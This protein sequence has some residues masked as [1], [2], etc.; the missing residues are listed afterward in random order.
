MPRNV[1]D[2]IPSH[3][4]SIRDVP[5]PEE[6]RTRGR[7]ATDRHPEE[8][9]IPIH[10][11]VESEE[12]HTHHYADAHH[13]VEEAPIP[14]VKN[15]I[16]RDTK[17]KSSKGIWIGGGIGVA[18]LAVAVLSLFNKA[19]LTYSPKVSELA[20]QNEAY[21]AYKTGG[22][23]ILLFSVVKVSDSK[24]MEVEATGEVQVSRKATGTII[25]YNDTSTAEQKLIKNTRFEA[26]DGH[27]Y[28]VLTDITI[29]GKTGST[30]GSLEINVTA[31][32]PGEA[33]NIALTDFTVP[34]LKGD[35]RYKTIYAR[36][37]TPMTG[38]LVGTE[39]GVN[40]ESLA[41]A[42]TNLENALK[43]QLISVAAAQVPEDFVIFPSLSQTFFED[44]PQS[45]ST[46]KTVTVNMKG[47]FYGVVFKRSDL[48]EYLKG[49]KLAAI[50]TQVIDIP[51][52]N[53]LAFNFEKTSEVDLLKATELKFTINGS[54][55]A[56]WQTDESAL[57]ND[58][59]D[60]SKSELAGILK[61]Y[62]GVA[63]AT[64]AIKPFWK[65]SFP[66]DTTKIE[67]KKNT[68]K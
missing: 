30:P 33:Y 59:K 3:K 39:K 16:T 25:V 40:A 58:L 23:G 18:L 4:R 53:T 61:N 21:T 6:R 35:P 20:F 56:E 7:R 48:A 22:D 8:I 49:K 19:T 17:K 51:D 10:K 27:I 11:E 2:I 45:S 5:I 43:E 54:A 37:K 41:K 38:G 42:K 44:M 68:L 46:G 26:K 57:K 50:G 24:G 28:R 60:K 47:D 55:T 67:I 32:Q 62:P 65:S 1:E 63:T 14:R 15:Q 64:V 29:P 12:I 52:L 13:H 66:G 36:S 34:G 31:D 9:P